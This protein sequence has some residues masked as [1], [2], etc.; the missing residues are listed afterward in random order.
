MSNIVSIINGQ[1]LVSTM[2]IAEGVGNP[3]K[4][5]I[6]LVRQNIKDLEEFG[7]VAFENAPFKTNGG[8]QNR[9][10]ALLNEDQATLLMTYMRNNDVVRAFKKRLV[11]AFRELRDNAKTGIAL[12]D[13]N[14]PQQVAGLL[15][16]SLQVV[17]SQKKKIEE[18]RPKVEALERIA[19][20]DGGMCITNAAKSLQLQP[21]FLFSWLQESKWIYRRVGGK[22][23]VGY[24]DKIQTGYL[25]HKVN[26]VARSDGS[27]KT[28]EQVLVTP[29]G[30]AKLSQLFVKEVAA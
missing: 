6:Q 5:V 14:N 13:F 3:H 18:D 20:S 15:A 17:E 16:Q 29:K 8:M 4:T 22:N 7:R 26:T 9:E 1:S 21:S 10:Y 23:W 2:A 19:L 30:L 11:K 28:V 12:I 24:Q 25:E 27:E